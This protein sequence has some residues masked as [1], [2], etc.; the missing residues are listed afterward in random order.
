M[1]LDERIAQE[2][3]A[4]ARHQKAIERGKMPARKLVRHGRKRRAALAIL[5]VLEKVKQ[6]PGM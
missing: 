1:T 5:A 3:K 4:V 2:R 6:L